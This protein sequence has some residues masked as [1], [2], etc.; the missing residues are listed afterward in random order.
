M[1]IRFAKQPGTRRIDPRQTLLELTQAAT[2]TSGRAWPAGTQL[3]PLCHGNTGV[4]YTVVGV[5]S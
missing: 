3:Q 5:Q 4:A 2:D 1:T